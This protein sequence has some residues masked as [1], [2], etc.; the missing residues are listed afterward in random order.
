MRRDVMKTFGKSSTE[1]VQ[2]ERERLAALENLDLLD[3]PRDE[4]FERIVRLIQ[5]VFTVDIGLV[6]V[7]D[8]HRQWY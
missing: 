6:S 3:S 8:A 2:R 1:L 5:T 4:G 7:I